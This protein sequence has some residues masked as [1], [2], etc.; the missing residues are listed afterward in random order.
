MPAWRLP[1]LEKGS[2]HQPWHEGDT[3]LYPSSG[4]QSGHSHP[5]GPGGA[6]LPMAASSINPTWWRRWKARPGRFSTGPSPRCN[7][8][9]GQPANLERCASPWWMCQRWHGQG[10]PPGSGPGGRQN[11]HSQVVAIDRDNPKEA[12]APDGRSRLV[13][14]YARP[15][16]PN[17]RGGP[18]GARRPRRRRRRPLASRVIAAACQ[19]PRWPRRNEEF[20]LS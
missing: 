16:T 14:G 5:D 19:N 3:I 11:R 2:I 20:V 17:G 15:T 18:G 9:W 8:V 13:C 4:L 12:R 10:R 6:P 7:P 1:G